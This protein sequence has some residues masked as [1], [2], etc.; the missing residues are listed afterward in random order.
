MASVAGP[1]QTISD[2]PSLVTRS[3]VSPIDSRQ[4]PSSR[5]VR[6][7]SCS[8]RSEL[9]RKDRSLL[10]DGGNFSETWDSVSDAGDAV[11]ASQRVLQKPE[12]ASRRI[13]KA[14]SMNFLVGI[15]LFQFRSEE[16]R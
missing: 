10:K 11:S 16:R 6:P 12:G 3:L 15:G 14:V 9:I 13:A 2:V 7:L 1:L 8:A 4:R 5:Q